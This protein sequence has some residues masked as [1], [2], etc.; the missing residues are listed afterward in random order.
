MSERT[1]VACGSLLCHRDEACPTCSTCGRRGHTACTRESVLIVLPLPPPE[2]SPNRKSGSRGGRMAT[3]R[4]TQ[5]YRQRAERAARQLQVESGPWARATVQA[6]FFHRAKRRRD[7][8]NFL[9]SLKPAYDGLVDAGLLEDDDAA[10]L[11]T[12][13]ATF[14]TDRDAPRVEL[15]VSRLPAQETDDHAGGDHGKEQQQPARRRRR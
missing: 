9:A 5:D 1:C 6:R 14:G 2:L 13:G 12:L 3:M 7:D 4:A 11:T 10:H 8:V 15:V